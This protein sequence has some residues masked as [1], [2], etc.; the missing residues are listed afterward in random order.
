M[1][2]QTEMSEQAGF[3]GR[4]ESLAA[5]VADA[6]QARDRGLRAMARQAERHAVPMMMLAIGRA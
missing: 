4:G 6:I 2:V 1:P 3:P 5:R